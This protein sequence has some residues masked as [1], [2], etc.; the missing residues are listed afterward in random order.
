M[1]SSILRGE[2][3]GRMIG[4]MKVVGGGLTPAQRVN[5]K[6]GGRLAWEELGS[7]AE[8]LIAGISQL[9]PFYPPSP[10]TPEQWVDFQARLLN[11]IHIPGSLAITPSN[12]VL[13]AGRDYL[14]H[15]GGPIEMTD[16]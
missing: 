16:A 2:G 7:A 14:T 4:S 9:G 5:G 8:R 15:D 12:L 13:T 3:S 11:Q 1:R 10:R 6:I